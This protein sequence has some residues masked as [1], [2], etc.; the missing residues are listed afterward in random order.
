[1]ASR[2]MDWRKCMAWVRAWIDVLAR[3]SRMRAESSRSSAS[4]DGDLVRRFAGMIQGTGKDD[5]QPRTSSVFIQKKGET[6]PR[7]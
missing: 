6:Y 4:T 2:R 5:T 7:L 1:M 3:W